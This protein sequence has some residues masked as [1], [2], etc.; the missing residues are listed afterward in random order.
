LLAL[1]QLHLQVAARAAH[2]REGRL[3]E[4]LAVLAAGH[5]TT[6]RLV[7]ERQDKDLMQD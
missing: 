5:I 1:Q 4:A 6:I 3:P 7:L 2:L